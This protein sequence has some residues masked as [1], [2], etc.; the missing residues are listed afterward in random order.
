MQSKTTRII[1]ALAILAAAALSATVAAGARPD[2]EDARPSPPAVD[3]NTDQVPPP[4]DATEDEIAAYKRQIVAQA[5]GRETTSAVTRDQA[6]LIGA[7]ARDRQSGDDVPDSVRQRLWRT[8]ELKRNRAGFNIDLARRVRAPRGIGAWI[9][10]GRDQICLITTDPAGERFG[11]SV[12]CQ[13][14]A[15]TTRG[16]LSAEWVA[17]DD[18][19]EGKSTIIGVVPDGV[20]EVTIRERNGSQ[21]SIPVQS[22]AYMVEGGRPTTVSF[23]GAGGRQSARL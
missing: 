20:A 13:G 16:E 14:L 10:P 21:R 11:F 12:D 22:N 23:S 6:Q 5:E 7:L 17:G 19:A 2:A 9:V 18:P 4:L 15:Q 3:A 1:A 8:R